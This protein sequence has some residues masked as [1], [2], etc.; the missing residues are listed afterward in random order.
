MSIGRFRL[1]GALTIRGTACWCGTCNLKRFLVLQWKPAESTWTFA[2]IQ[3]T[4]ARDSF[5]GIACPLRSLF[6]LGMNA[7]WRRSAR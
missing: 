1:D 6:W 4:T 2:Y 7:F 5:L 3:R